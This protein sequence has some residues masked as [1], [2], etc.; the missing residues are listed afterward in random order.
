MTCE[1][2][3][4]LRELGRLLALLR[5]APAGWVEAAQDLP[6]ARRHLDDLLA[7]AAADAELRARLV[8]DLESALAEA[9]IAPTPHAVEAAR[10]RLD[11]R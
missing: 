9:G 6:R 11:R 3:H 4:E 1:S 2:A 8:A 10:A 7:R 5:P